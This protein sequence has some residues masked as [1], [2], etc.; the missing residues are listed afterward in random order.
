MWPLILKAAYCK[1]IWPL[2]QLWSHAGQSAIVGCRN[3][4]YDLEKSAQKSV[5]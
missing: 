3:G 5:F 4:L 2:P 1:V